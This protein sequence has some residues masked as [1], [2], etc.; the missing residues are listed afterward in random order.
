MKKVIVFISILVILVIALLINIDMNNEEKI[1][2]EKSDYNIADYETAIFAGG[3]FWCMEPPFEKL[4]GV[5]DA[6]SGYTGG[7]LENPTYEQ[8]S[9]G[10]T[11]HIE[12]VKVVY[13]AEEISYEELLDVFWRQIDPT[14]SGGQFVDRGYQY[15]SAIFYK[16]EEEK[17]LAEESLKAL[18]A[19]GRFEEEIVTPIREAS[20]FYNAEEYHQDYYIKSDVKY[21]YY[22]SR[23]GRDEFLN[24]VWG[25]NE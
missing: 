10:S 8:V 19:S 13:D 7:T 4:D 6:V 23:S 15:T 2:E 5:I 14:D 18:E 11:K 12:A 24:K 17:K 1:I 16:T 20:E 25:N 3:C 22:R 21:K 9:S